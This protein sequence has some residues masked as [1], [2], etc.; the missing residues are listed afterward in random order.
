MGTAKIIATIINAVSLV[1]DDGVESSL[2][3]DL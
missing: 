2:H 1:Q 3:F